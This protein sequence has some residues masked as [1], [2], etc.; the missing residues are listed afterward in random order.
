MTTGP[1]RSA[2]SDALYRWWKQE[3]ITLEEAGARHGVSDAAF[4][5]WVSGKYVPMRHLGSFEDTLGVDELEAFRLVRTPP[6]DD[7]FS[8]A[9]AMR[10]YVSYL[11]DPLGEVVTALRAPRPAALVF[12]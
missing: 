1:N 12:A 5:Y 2:L 4:H 10:R 6:D 9:G 3:G 7:L 8:A 11:T